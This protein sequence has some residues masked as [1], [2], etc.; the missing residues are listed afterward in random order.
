MHSTCSYGHRTSI[1]H[2][3]RMRPF[4]IFCT[5]ST[6]LL[7]LNYLSFELFTSFSK[8]EQFIPKL[9]QSPFFNLQLMA[10]H[11]SGKSLAYLLPVLQRI[12]FSKNVTQALCVV[13]S[14][15]A[16]V[17][18]VNWL[19]RMAMYLENPNRIGAAIQRTGKNTTL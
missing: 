17:Q 12:D 10:H 8:K 11:G 9:L 4:C 3:G 6:Y 2:A 7:N 14:Y 18:T 19:A 5:L 16:A 1:T 13:I 15:E